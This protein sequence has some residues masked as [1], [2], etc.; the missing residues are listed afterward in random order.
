MRY[1]EATDWNLLEPDS[2]ASKATK[3]NEA[4]VK[5][6]IK[7][8]S[9]LKAIVQTYRSNVLRGLA[10]LRCRRRRCFNFIAKQWVGLFRASFVCARCCFVDLLV[11]CGVVRFVVL[12]V[13]F[14]LLFVFC[15]VVRLI[16]LLL[17]CVCFLAWFCRVALSFGVV[18]FCLCS[19]IYVA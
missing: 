19:G 13:L 10:G 3:T 7:T 9:K 11:C 8:W 2:E 15:V 1:N 12:L 18:L 14:S 16:R 5:E 4:N 6:K 17:P